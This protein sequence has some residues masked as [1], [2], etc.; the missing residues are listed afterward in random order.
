M[1]SKINEG[2][3]IAEFTKP[4]MKKKILENVVKMLMERGWIEEEEKFDNINTDKYNIKGIDKNIHI[5]FI[6]DKNILRKKSF[7]KNINLENKKEHVI[8]ILDNPKLLTT[9]KDLLKISNV[10]I[11]LDNK[12]TMNIA[13]HILVPKHRIMSKKEKKE[14][15]ETFN[16][17]FD[18][19]P[20]IK[21]NDAMAKYHNASVG[22][23]IEITRYSKT[24][25]KHITYRYVRP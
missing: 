12:F 4:Q 9:E 2:L 25:G 3:Y 10:E 16:L 14:F 24:A 15:A 20:W 1:E 23:L 7:M 8:V 18:K 21:K 22:D 6:Q 13:D 17:T 5:F 11:W 19:V